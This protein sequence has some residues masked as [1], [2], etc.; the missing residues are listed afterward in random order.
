MRVADQNVANQVVQ[1]PALDDTQKQLYYW[2]FQHGPQPTNTIFQ[3]F[4]PNSGVLTKLVEL[5]LVNEVSQ[6]WFDVTNQ[7]PA[8]AQNGQAVPPPDTSG[9]VI[10][11]PPRPKLKKILPELKS[12]VTH[13][14]TAS[15]AMPQPYAPSKEM[16]QLVAWMEQEVLKVSKTRAK[17]E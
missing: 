4:D 2:L 1:S 12:L 5:N 11:R 8:Q 14:Q 16:Q 3:Y 7:L 17:K 10:P 15:A 6:G 9:K 13:M